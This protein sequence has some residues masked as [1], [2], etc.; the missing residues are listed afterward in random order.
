MKFIEQKRELSKDFKLETNELKTL[1]KTSEIERIRLL[2]L[3]KSLQK[4][5]EDLN[6]KT[7]E[8]ENRLNE[9]RRRNANLEKQLEKSKISDPK[10]GLK[11]YVNQIKFMP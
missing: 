11:F 3:V 6:E 1:H 4:R 8:S 7:M 2:D 10:S 9:Q 5:I